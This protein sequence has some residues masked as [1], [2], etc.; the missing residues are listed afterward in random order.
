MAA[1]LS[2]PT[3]RHFGYDIP[4]RLMNLTGGGPDTFDFIS[5][6]HMQTM[7]EYAPVAP[8]HS[9]L[10]IGCGIGR[11]AIPLTEIIGRQGSYLG[12]DIIKDSIDWC[13]ENI[14]KNHP[15]FK[16]IHYDIQ[17]Q[18]HNP[19]GIS[20]TSQIRLPI[21]KQSV[22]RIILRSVFTHMFRDD[23]VHY[24]TEFERVLKPNGLVYATWFIVD[25]A[26][27]SKAQK[28]NL[29]PF[30]LRFEHKIGEGCYIEDP[31]HPLGAVAYTSD[32]LMD[33]IRASGLRLFGDIHRGSWSGYWK[34]TKGAQDATVLA[35][36]YAEKFS[37]TLRQ[38]LR[39]RL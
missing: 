9:V 15:N 23:I 30:N 31:V 36:P 17:D 20:K 27:I 37:R 14:T 12:I 18:L 22:D 28:T 11:D 1:N 38:A 4:T 26:V 3:T 8:S 24:L 33:M 13:S 35:L 10:E 39:L 19:H 5:Q 29:T 7:K 6:F 32:A 25:S 2:E 34:S 16:F 21:K